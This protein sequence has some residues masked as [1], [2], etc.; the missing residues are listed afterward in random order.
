MTL[1]F[2][3]PG[4][5]AGIPASSPLEAALRAAGARFEERHG[6][7]VPV[8]FGSPEAEVE[9]CRGGVGIADRS[10]MG[11][12]ELQARPE[13]LAGVL[14]RL[15]PE[16]PP[17]P[18][19]IALLDGARL[20]LASADRALAVCEPE[21]TA[22]VRAL[23][24]EGSGG[25]VELTAGLA[26]LELR[27]PL[28]RRLLERV[29]AIDARPGSLPPGGVRAG[30]VARVPGVLLCLERDAVL[31]LVGAPEAPDAWEILLDAGLPLG[32]RPVGEEARALL[33][34]PLEG[35]PARA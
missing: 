33:R 28:A 14:R 26:A 34:Q 19:D 32:L 4:A 8:D 30:M 22:G 27:G 17:R 24:S 29:T 25:V 21:A 12:L 35:A 16:G 15:L 9:A 18:G 7:R 23:L 11:K 31:L 13:A 3:S 5:A 10:A 1:E 20:W 2:L 6:W